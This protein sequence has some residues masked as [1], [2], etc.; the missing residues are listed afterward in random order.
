MRHVSMRQDD[1]HDENDSVASEGV[2]SAS[3]V[4]RLLEF[5]VLP[6]ALS[7]GWWFGA[8]LFGEAELQDALM[9]AAVGFVLALYQMFQPDD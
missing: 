9:G 2:R 6:L 4:K 1:D 5:V 8:S 7:A 3:R